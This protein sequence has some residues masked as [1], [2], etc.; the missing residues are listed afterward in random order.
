MDRFRVELEETTGA[1]TLKKEIRLGV[2]GKRFQPLTDD[3][4]VSLEQLSD[5]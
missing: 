5:I 2:R 4:G 1:I 3:G